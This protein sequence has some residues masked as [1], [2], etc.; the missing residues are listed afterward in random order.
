MKHI[1]A[2]AALALT[3]PAF[4][5]GHHTPAPIVEPVFPPPVL[6]PIPAPEPTPAPA[7]IMTMA[8]QQDQQQA[9]SQAQAQQQSQAANSASASKSK[10]ASV[11]NSAAN[12]G[13]NSVSVGG[14]NAALSAS[15][16]VSN[17]R[18]AASAYAPAIAPTAPCMGSSSAGFQGMSFGIS[19]G[20]TW[21]DTNCVLLEQIRTV[22][23]VLGQP[24]IASEMMCAVE[25]YREARE[26]IGV[27][28]LP[29][30]VAQ[31]KYSDPVVRRRMALPPATD[32]GG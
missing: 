15:L 5:G 17:E 30:K 23:V 11:S 22:S 19:A 21:T 13:G 10:S 3:L 26:R 1:I 28:C 18:S 20:G 12:N 7:P 8:Q 9:Q 31:V 16:S 25:S 29:V 27:P 14:N 24:V 32:N 2:V 4:A 6:E